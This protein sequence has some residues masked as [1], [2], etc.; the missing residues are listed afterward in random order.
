VVNYNTNSITFDWSMTGDGVASGLG[1]I[2]NGKVLPAASATT[3]FHTSSGGVY[4]MTIT[5]PLNGVATELSIV[6]YDVCPLTTPE[7]PTP[8]EVTKT[9]TQTPE[10]TETTPV[11]TPEE[12]LPVPVTGITPAALIPVTGADF[13]AARQTT[14][15]LQGVLFNLGLA[16]FG[17]GLVTQAVSRRMQG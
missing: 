15:N 8:T 11:A 17:I 3:L 1:A 10:E 9:V 14:G 5:Y 13:T 12:T 4:T 6:G 16:F 7:T 2:A